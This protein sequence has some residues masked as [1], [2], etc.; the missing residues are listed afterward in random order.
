M[1]P[2][3]E[4]MPEVPAFD[5]SAYPPNTCF[6]ERR[7]GRDRRR[8]QEAGSDKPAEEALER[9]RRRRNERRRRVDPTTFEKQYTADEIEFMNAM[10]HYKVQSGKTFPSYGEVLRVA[11][12][13][14]YAR[15]DVPEQSSNAMVD[16]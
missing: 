7:S 1:S 11:L 15:T 5:F 14:G 8:D 12:T 2:E 9:P 6:H 16:A 13:L 3:P 10:Q 4:T